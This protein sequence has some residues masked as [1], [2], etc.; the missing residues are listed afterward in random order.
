M[1]EATAVEAG[2]GRIVLDNPPLNILTGDVLRRLE[3]E[4]RALADQSDLRV[5]LLTATGSTSRR[6][7]AASTSAA[8]SI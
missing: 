8:S 7:D 1:T 5:L 3:T 2:I 6:A 4:L